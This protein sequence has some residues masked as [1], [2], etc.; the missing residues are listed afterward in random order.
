MRQ[1][2]R[3]RRCGGRKTLARDPATYPNRHA[4]PNKSCGQ[5][6]DADRYACKHC[7]TAMTH[8]PVCA[9]GGTFRL[10]RWANARPWR[11]HLCHC[12]GYH[13]VITGSPHR[14]GGGK[15]IYNPKPPIPD[16]AYEFPEA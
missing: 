3:C 11:K 16:G 15:C 4:C 1:H 13:W 10:D 2:C 5:P 14:R 8:G 6:N 9:C 7:G 12:D